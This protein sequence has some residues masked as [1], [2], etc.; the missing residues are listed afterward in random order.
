MPDMINSSTLISG[1]EII[2]SRGDITEVEADAIVNAANKHLNHGG[3]VAAAIARK[4]G[5]A[6]QEESS[7]WVRDH[8]PVPHDRPAYTTGGELKCKYV[9]HAVGPVKG[10]EDGDRKLADAVEGSLL[11]AEE[12]GLSSIAFPAI[13]TGIFGFPIDRAAEI[14]MD[15]IQRYYRNKPD[16]P[17][18][19]V[20]IVLFDNHSMDVFNREFE[21]VFKPDNGK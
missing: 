13:S 4:G 8:G 3:G 2:I 10:E 15:T 9:I 5:P 17:I 12:Q 19:T 18:K 16:S 14:F 6:I 20:Q 11:R 1:Q 21:K 7:R